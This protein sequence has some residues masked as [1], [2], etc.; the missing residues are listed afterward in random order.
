VNRVALVVALLLAAAGAGLLW[1]YKQ[2]LQTEIGGGP[3]VPV[4]MATRDIPLGTRIT[5]EHLGIRRVP[6]SFLEDRHIRARDVQQVV[7][8]RATTHVSANESLLWTDLESATT[9][10][11]NLAGLIRVG[12]RAI[13]IPA[14]KESVF[15]EL[16]RPGDRVDALLTTEH[17]SGERATVPVA[18]NVL[19]LAIGD[20]TGGTEPNSKGSGKA[21]RGR[22]A[23]V[24]LAVSI[25]EAHRLT[26]A[27]DHGTLSLILRNHEDNLIAKDQPATRTA[28]VFAGVKGSG[29]APPPPASTT[30][31]QLAAAVKAA[32]E[33]TKRADT[34]EEVAA[35]ERER[36]E[37]GDRPAEDDRDDDRKKKRGGDR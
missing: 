33:A 30:T 7:G 23:T 2:R 25:E 12:M 28:D 9:Q 5:E 6:Q 18:Q 3:R 11:R 13:A 14:T 35:D 29:K 36:A 31:A 32:E 10:Q 15:S 22:A 8:V 34:P 16:L 21:A 37:R 26:L 4:L 20:D 1:L 17:A 19:V 24:T 27:L